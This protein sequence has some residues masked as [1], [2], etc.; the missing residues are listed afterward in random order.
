M[1]GIKISKESLENFN[2]GKTLIPAPIDN[3]NLVE[4][5]FDDDVFVDFYFAND[6]GKDGLRHL[7]G[8]VYINDLETY[9]DGIVDVSWNYGNHV[10]GIELKA[11]PGNEDIVQMRKELFAHYAKVF[12][13]W[14][15]EGLVVKFSEIANK[16][17]VS[18]YFE[19]H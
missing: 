11:V 15:N 10:I 18:F 17:Y 4:D 13:E 7:I 16:L 14:E 3:K 9:V 19:I 6:H 5:A 2:G 8:A 1:E 12:K